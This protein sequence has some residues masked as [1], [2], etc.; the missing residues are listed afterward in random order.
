MTKKKTLKDMIYSMKGMTRNKLPSF[1]NIPDNC[2]STKEEENEIE[3]TEN[4]ESEFIDDI[5]SDSEDERPG[6]FPPA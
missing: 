6:W 5:C 2:L 3:F 4:N 1:G